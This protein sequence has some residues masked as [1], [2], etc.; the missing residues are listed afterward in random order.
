MIMPENRSSNAIT[1]YLLNNRSLSSLM[2][3]PLDNLNIKVRKLGHRIPGFTGPITGLALNEDESLVYASTRSGTVIAVSRETWECVKVFTGHGWWVSDVAFNSNWIASAGADKTVRLWDT[4]G[5]CREVLGGHTDVVTAVAF[6]RDGT[7][8]ATASR[9]KVVQVY[10]RNRAGRWQL[11]RTFRG[12]EK[13]VSSVCFADS[14]RVVSAGFE[15]ALLWDARNCRILARLSE[16]EKEKKE[17][18]LMLQSPFDLIYGHRVTASKVHC[19][20]NHAAIG[21]SNGRVYVWDLTTYNCFRKLW[22]VGSALCVRLGPEGILAA[23]WGGHDHISVYH[24]ANESDKATDVL[25]GHTDY[26]L[27]LV[28][29]QKGQI[30]SAGLDS[31]IVEWDLE[32]R[33]PLSVYR[34]GKTRSVCDIDVRADSVAVGGEDNAVSVYDLTTGKRRFRYAGLNHWVNV[35]VFSPDGTWVA[36][37]TRDGD[38]VL[39]DVRSGRL[40]A[41]LFCGDEDEVTHMAFTG[42][43]TCLLVGMRSG[44]LFLFDVATGIRMREYQLCSALVHHVQF[45]R[46]DTEYLAACWDGNVYRVL[47]SSG[48]RLSTY[49]P[50]N[51]GRCQEVE[52]AMLSA[53]GKSLITVAFDGRVRI[54]DFQSAEMLFS[55]QAHSGRTRSMAIR[56]DIL[57]TGG[58]D[59]CI[60]V[61]EWKKQRLIHTVKDCCDSIT[62]LHFTK[63]GD[64]LI[65]G[66]REGTVRFFYCKSDYKLL[67]TLYS[68]ADGDCLWET[69]DGYFHTNRPY[70]LLEVFE[71]D[72]DGQKALVLPKEDPR[73]R[74]YIAA[75][76]SYAHVKGAVL[77]GAYQ[78]KVD[79]FKRLVAAHQGAKHIPHLLSASN[80]IE[81]KAS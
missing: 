73:A 71:S 29:T 62:S 20:G 17:P 7:L 11:M 19:L 60:R 28:I 8:L 63:N 18:G 10:Y 65:A 45:L 80:D 48:N 43:G 1:Q 79:R 81:N 30:I 55:F 66:S 13:W 49:T 25:L 22:S 40:H 12:H 74:S 68:L 26:P 51:T 31:T 53:D 2:G 76:N 59:A 35:V 69:P 23:G 3:S 78:A 37:G 4:D 72:E 33:T 38:A 44:K 9:D 50:Q 32:A 52:M 24:L 16:P 70:D 47:V 58:L 64:R 42:D 77:G 61:W 15:E 46:R 6:N 67:A 54:F 34:A 14:H 36:G 5:N 21:H 39:V 75:H 56:G 57:A 27:A 41:D